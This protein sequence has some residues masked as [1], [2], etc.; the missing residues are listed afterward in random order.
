M[1]EDA[2]LDD[3]MWVLT[4]L[5]AGRRLEEVLLTVIELA[6]QSEHGGHLMLMVHDRDHG[7]LQPFLY[8]SL[9]E[10]VADALRGLRVADDGPAGGASVATGDVT[11][12]ADIADDERFID[13]REMLLAHGYRSCWSAPLTSIADGSRIGSADLYRSTPGLPDE[14]QARTHLS[15]AALA[16]LA[17]EVDAQT[18]SLRYRATH[19]PLTALPNRALFAERLEPAAADGDVG[20]LFIDLDRSKLVN[21]T[22]GHDF[23]DEV[24]QAVAARLAG[25][26]QEPSV[27]SRFG[28]DEFTVLVPKVASLQE[29]VVEARRLLGAISEPYE[30]RGL[31]ISIDASAGASHAAG[32]V[33]EPVS[34]IRDAD[35]ALHRAKQR[36]RSRVEVFD[37]PMLVA[38][39]E[40]MR[41]ERALRDALEAGLVFAEFQPEI[42]LSDGAVVGAEALARCRTADGET[43]PPATFIPVAEETGLITAVFDAVLDQACDAVQRWSATSAV[44]FTVWVNLSAQQLGWRDLNE[45]IHRAIERSGADPATLGFEVT[46]QG[47][48]PDPAEADA[49]LRELAQLGCRLAVDDFGTGYSSLGY[50]LDLP[51]DTVKLD[52]S[53]IVRA[54]DDE[55]SRSIVGAVISLATAMGLTCVAEGVETEA[56]LAMVSDFGCD[57][58]QGYIYARPMPEPELTQWLQRQV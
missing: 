31:K 27:V 45:Q 53:F 50:L 11:H 35:T 1:S 30:V 37:S 52:R 4:R 6:E 54:T 42:R 15:A 36:G 44:P 18:S 8:P 22:L 13:L 2:V 55:R 23:G 33:S 17:L 19:D 21:D 5:A 9:P 3:Q 28:G 51:V 20:V 43:I 48:M 32:E 26:V 40:R 29:L 25:L 39:E 7:V 57:V 34:L 14:H 47:I 24:L 58:V 38:H 49:R 12:S 10:D 16:G 56:Q 46:E 41:V